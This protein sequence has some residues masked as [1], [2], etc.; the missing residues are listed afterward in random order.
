[1]W[2]LGHGGWLDGHG[3]VVGLDELRGLFQ[4]YQYCDSMTPHANRHTGAINTI[5]YIFTN[6]PGL[7]HGYT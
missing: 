4:Y 2:P 1:M 6:V 5:T 3:L 7:F